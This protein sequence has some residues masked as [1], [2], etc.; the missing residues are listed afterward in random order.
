ML[1]DHTFGKASRG[2]S[3]LVEN[4]KAKL[5]A[6]MDLAASDFKSGPDPAKVE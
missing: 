6:R 1:R 2:E 3:L 4:P 5:F